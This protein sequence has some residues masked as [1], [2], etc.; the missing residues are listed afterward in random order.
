MTSDEEKPSKT[1]RKKA[2]HALQALGEELVALTAEQL[3]RVALPELLRDAV[4]AARRITRFEAKR[5]QLQYIGKLMRRVEVEPIRAALDAAL[6]RS[7]GEA[8][9]HKRIEA[10]RERLLADPG[11]VNEL[12][13][14]FPGADRRQL[15]AL[16]RAALRERAEGRPPR[17][18]RELYQALRALIEHKVTKKGDE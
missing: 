16:A 11:A 1:Q 17:A 5:R 13:A 7:R 6:A 2:V 15:R 12:V 8:A 4:M 3:A 9:A 14:D 10:W 18:F